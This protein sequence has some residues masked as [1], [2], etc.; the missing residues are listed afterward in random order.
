MDVPPE[1][2][3]VDKTWTPFLPPQRSCFFSQAISTAKALDPKI[4]PRIPLLLE[5][6]IR[7]WVN[8]LPKDFLK[9]QIALVE[10]K[11]SARP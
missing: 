5:Q 2:A 1:L 4:S 3:S 6:M 10:E 8:G 9:K 11:V 7:K